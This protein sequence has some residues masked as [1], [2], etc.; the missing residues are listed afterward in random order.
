[1][2]R[3]K[4]KISAEYKNE[5]I[6][7]IECI[8]WDPLEL[9]SNA[10][11]ADKK[12]ED[13]KKKKDTFA[14]DNHDVFM[15]DT[16]A[17][18]AKSKK[19]RVFC[20]IIFIT[21]KLEMWESYICEQFKQYDIARRPLKGNGKQGMLGHSLV[22]TLNGDLLVTVTFWLKKKKIMIQPGNKD[23]E[24]LFEWMRVMKP[25]MP[26]IKDT[27]LQTTTGQTSYQ[28]YY[29]WSDLASGRRCNQST[30]ASALT[31]PVSA[32]TI[33]V[34][35]ATV[36]VSAAP[37]PVSAAP[38]HMSAASTA[39]NVAAQ[40]RCPAVTLN[41]QAAPFRSNLTF[42]FSKPICS[43]SATAGQTHHKGNMAANHAE[44]DVKLIDDPF[45]CFL[46]NK[47]DTTAKDILEKVCV[48]FYQSSTIANSKSILF[49]NVNTDRRYK[50]HRGQ[51]Q[52][53]DDFK[54]IYT[55]LQEAGSD[56]PVKFVVSNLSD[57]PPMR[58]ESV[59]IAHLLK[60]IQDT[61]TSV[62]L[63]TEAHSSMTSRITRFEQLTV[64]RLS[65]SPSPV[66][67]PKH[68]ACAEVPGFSEPKESELNCTNSSDD[69]PT[70]T[71]SL[72]S[73]ET[74]SEATIQSI[75]EDPQE[76]DISAREMS[77]IL[78]SGKHRNAAPQSHGY[79]D[80]LTH[81]SACGTGLRATQPH[82][83]KDDKRINSDKLNNVI[84]GSGSGTGLRA[85]AR[86]SKFANS[87]VN[88]STRITGVFI[89]R[90]DPKTTVSQVQT[91][92]KRETG[93]RVR[94]EKL[95]AKYDTYSSFYIG[96]DK[97]VQD[98]LL[99]GDMWPKGAL[100]KHFVVRAK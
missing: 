98:T 18:S 63:L 25:V 66:L 13:R 32:A 34:S 79:R 36:S 22:L 10:R 19:S 71:D 95:Q 17:A 21:D 92:V 11:Q 72:N 53:H 4:D 75:E 60:Q 58:I 39:S 43:A 2:S 57:L 42:S 90:L 46:H 48:D 86:N 70:H 1:M 28:R 100:I 77:A 31:V 76:V 82:D 38:V 8:V 27:S 91:V 97:R 84:H 94:A 52:A 47:M 81:G 24:N 20:D 88:T 80:A 26:S 51:N 5:V 99:C 7:G 56:M 45:L 14:A 83:H 40:V 6:E 55:I 61:N 64:N 78:G 15:L 23:E 74:V 59:D 44:H 9:P 62:K 67:P 87:N 3:K 65:S 93:L 35:A 49:D 29:K 12:K 16:R 68:A 96:C 30:S 33:P 54:D 50:K 89:T 85:I 73:F 37:I 41:A 69:F